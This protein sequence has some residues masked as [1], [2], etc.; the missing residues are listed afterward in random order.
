MV[1]RP[2]VRHLRPVGRPTINRA[3]VPAHELDRRKHTRWEHDDKVRALVAASPDGMTLDAVG[4]YFG[5]TRERARQLEF[6]ALRKLR[7]RGIDLK[8][9]LKGL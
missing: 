9:L 8:Q 6:L 2:S 5:I 3:R 4:A 7:I 1:M